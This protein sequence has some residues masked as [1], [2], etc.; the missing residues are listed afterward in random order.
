MSAEKARLG[1]TK[2]IFLTSQA[3]HSLR[4]WSRGPQSACHVLPSTSSLRVHPHHLCSVRCMAT[5]RTE[6]VGSAVCADTGLRRA[7]VEEFSLPF[8]FPH[9][10][11]TWLGLLTSGQLSQASPTP[12]PSLS[13]WSRLGTFWQLSRM[14]LIPTRKECLPEPANVTGRS[15]EHLRALQRSGLCTGRRSVG[16]ACTVLTGP[17]PAPAVIWREGRSKGGFWET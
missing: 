17:L 5:P 11:L 16:S 10:L 15:G 3:P 2:P 13:R 4:D 12:S 6:R 9:I 8:E 1:I 7:C 14:F